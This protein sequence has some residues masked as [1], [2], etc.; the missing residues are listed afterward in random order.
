MSICE[1]IKEI[2]YNI[3]YA[4]L[5][6]GR[7]AKDIK[8]LAVT[9]TI[10][11]NIIK[12][13]VNCGITA[14]GENKVQEF[15]S[16]YEELGNILEYHFIGALQTNK[17]KYLIN[18]VALIHSVDSFKLAQ[19]INRQ[20]SKIGTISDVLIEINIGNELSKSGVSKENIYG[21]LDKISVF[22]N[23]SIKGLMTIPPF[24][25]NNEKTREYFKRMFNLF[26]DIRAKKLDNV[27]MDFLSMGMSMDYIIAIEEGANIVRIG[28][29]IFG[30]RKK[31]D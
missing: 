6:S 28:N 26:I 5:K 12:E 30:E 4:A 9:K 2:Q 29:K 22:P 3:S 23:I 11:V 27:N 1:N 15:L 31:E 16:K 24:T 14:I 13:A 17:V 7:T 18:K 19:E 20:S 21:L 8:L 25:A 10:P